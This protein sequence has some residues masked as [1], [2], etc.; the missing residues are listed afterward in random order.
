[1]AP[2]ISDV[3]ELRFKVPGSRQTLRIREA[4]PR[5]GGDFVVT[6]APT[7]LNPTK[8]KDV[9]VMSKNSDA[10]IAEDIFYVGQSTLNDFPVGNNLYVQNS[11]GQSVTI[12]EL[13]DN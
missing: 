12:V 7:S 9:G 4:T 13:D 11:A 2:E 8:R 1:M 6:Q 10:G 5:A 3:L